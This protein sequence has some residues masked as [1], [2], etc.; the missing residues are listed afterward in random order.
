MALQ[1]CQGL[2]YLAKQGLSHN[3]LRL[4]NVLVDHHQNVKLSDFGMAGPLSPAAQDL[5]HL[6]LL[7]NT[8]LQGS[9]PADPQLQQVI[10]MCRQPRGEAAHVLAQ[11]LAILRPPSA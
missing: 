4:A 10:G 11:V 5:P 6:A 7:L 1:L 2:L 9:P 3:D 8:L